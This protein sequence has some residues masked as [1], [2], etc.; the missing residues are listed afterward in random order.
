MGEEHDDPFVLQLR[1][2]LTTQMMVMCL[3]VS[4]IMKFS[5]FFFDREMRE[6]L[7]ITWTLASS[8]ENNS[9]IEGIGLIRIKVVLGP[10]SGLPKTNE[11]FM[12][13]CPSL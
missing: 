7:Y 4:M 11:I 3:R 9:L 12:D 5:G 13:F 2:A 6:E 8:P 10:V 1:A